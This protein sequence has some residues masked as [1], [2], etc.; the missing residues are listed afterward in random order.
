MKTRKERDSMG[1]LAVP[2]NALY[3][4][5]TQRAVNNFPISGRPMPP[6]FISALAL[7]KKCAAE[8]NVELG[9]LN[10]R[11]REGDCGGG[12]GGD[13]GQAFAGFSD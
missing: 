8:A 6:T 2:A 4:A 13:G 11:Y 10:R 3:Q 1:E 7:V 12:E 5:Q 9:L